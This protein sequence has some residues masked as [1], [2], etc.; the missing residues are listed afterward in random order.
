MQLAFG[1]AF[2][3]VAGVSV[4]HA[5]GAVA[6]QQHLHQLFAGLLLL[7]RVSRI[8]GKQCQQGNAFRFIQ[9]IQ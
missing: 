8:L 5:P 6:I 1:K 4:K 9:F 2:D 3:A 7:M